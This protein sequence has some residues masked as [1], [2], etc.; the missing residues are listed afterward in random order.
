MQVASGN[1]ISRA[2]SPG[3]FRTF[4][5]GQFWECKIVKDAPDRSGNGTSFRIFVPPNSV[6]FRFSL[7]VG[8]SGRGMATTFCTRPSLKQQP[9]NQKQQDNI[10]PHFE[11]SQWLDRHGFLSSKF[12]TH[13]CVRPDIWFSQLVCPQSQS[14]M[15][16]RTSS[17]ILRESGNNLPNFTQRGNQGMRKPLGR[18]DGTEQLETLV[19]GLQQKNIRN[20]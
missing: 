11:S 3:T 4:Y 15:R 8:N 19:C 5:F 14:M 9:S 10:K 13:I 17:D 7:N 1:R 20:F 2:P 6:R 16:P 18:A 12:D